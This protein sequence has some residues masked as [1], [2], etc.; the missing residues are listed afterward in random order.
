MSENNYGALMMK[1][2]LIASVNI[3]SII[4]PGVYPVNAG[5]FSCPD[6]EGG[7][8]TVHPT[9]VKLRTFSSNSISSATST[10]NS[11]S[12]TWNDWIIVW[13][14][15][16][17][18]IRFRDFGIKGN[19]TDETAGIIA[20]ANKANAIGAKLIADYGST[21]KISG[22]QN[23]AFMNDVDWND[24]VIL[25]DDFT[26]KI[27]LVRPPEL[28][29]RILEYDSPE[30]Q[31]IRNK[32]EIIW[33]G[34]INAW[35]NDS[36]LQNYYIVVETNIPGFNYRGTHYTLTQRNR[37]HRGGGLAHNF[38]YPMP[39]NSIQRIRL[40]P[41]PARVRE[42]KNVT[43]HRDYNPLNLMTVSHSRIKL[44]N[45]QFSNKGGLVSTGMIYL[46]ATED[47]YDMEWDNISA[48]FGQLYLTDPSDPNTVAASYVF[49]IGD[50]YNV[51]L[52]DLN[53]NG[54]EWGTIGTDEIT[55]CLIERCK[56]SRYDSHRPYH[57][58]LTFVSCTIGAK[59]VSAQ[60][61]SNGGK[62]LY[63]GCTIINIGFNDFN[64]ALVL[65]YF[66]GSRGDAGGIVDA[67]LVYDDCTF[68]NNLP[69]TVHLVGQVWGPSFSDGIPNGSP[70]RR[71]CFRTVT[72][73]NPTVKTIPGNNLSVVD[74]GI[75][76]SATGTTD[77]FTP[78]GLNTPDLPFNIILNNIKSRE[79]GLVSVSIVC[80]RPASPDRATAITTSD[81]NATEMNTNIEV[82]LN[83][84][85]L[86]DRDTG[87]TLTDTTGTYS[88]RIKLNGVRQMSDL[89]EVTA[90][91]FMPHIGHAF[92]CSIREIRP[93]LN[94]VTLT[95]PMHWNFT[96]CRLYPPNAFISWSTTAA[97]RSANISSCTILADSM[98]TLAKM[99][100][101]KLTSCEYILK[102]TGPVQ[103]PITES[104]EGA[105][106]NLLNV[107]WMTTNNV[108]RIELDQ[109][110]WPITIPPPT[111]AIYMDLGFT[112]DGV[113]P[114]RMKIYRSSGSGGALGL[115]KFNT[116]LPTFIYLP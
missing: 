18:I 15:K 98:S 70:I 24:S 108:Y 9:P 65:P 56:L 5:N 7:M 29:P 109:G 47:C 51:H 57:G 96:G 81:T 61:A 89:F 26:G 34:V 50:S 20:A 104:L 11:N 40:Y 19:G 48:P 91:V 76:E 103:V 114:K 33:G 106:A 93:F 97:N 42:F 95:K 39:A 44:S 37:L 14:R 4:L 30:I 110:S 46:N 64:P 99:A 12:D 8:L 67:D 90:R 32:G 13:S 111:K 88:A 68:V 58:S 3:D 86:T 36:S 78:T 43:F 66:R 102:G 116:P 80:T 85:V 74:F 22:S 52:H 41:V 17:N 59:G 28:E 27:N 54:L 35:A 69:H 6:I 107:D 10:Y 72:V 23:I 79:D 60:G 77:G 62:E 87:L 105:S 25:H 16:G 92:G 113:T 49:R 94:G 71:V 82:N 2:A 100:A 84:C 1:S 83:D 55:N 63:I 45:I 73:N 38:D 115:T 31:A 112:E 53:A 75:R 101:Y 21:I